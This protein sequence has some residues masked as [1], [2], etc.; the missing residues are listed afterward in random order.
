MPIPLFAAV[1][2]CLLFLFPTADYQTRTSHM[3]VRSSTP[4]PHPQPHMA[5]F[6]LQ[7]QRWVIMTE[8]IKFARPKIFTIYSF[9]ERIA[10]T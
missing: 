4:E 10:N 9:T 5:V 2:A 8:I 7:G 3:L 6:I 1:T